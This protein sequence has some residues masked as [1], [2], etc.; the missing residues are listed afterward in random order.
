MRYAQ[1]KKRDEEEQ[2]T[3]E[4]SHRYD[5]RIC[6]MM[7]MLLSVIICIGVHQTYGGDAYDD[8][9]KHGTS[10]RMGAQISPSIIRIRTELGQLPLEF[11]AAHLSHFGVR[12]NQ[13][14]VRSLAEVAPIPNPV[15][16][17]SNEPEPHAIAGAR[18]PSAVC[19][20]R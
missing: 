19:G 14:L 10:A 7:L 5:T 2:H 8:V 11:G 18:S 17:S 20:E 6:I 15:H 12:P 16:E 9:E 13:Y 1:A 3:K 4:K